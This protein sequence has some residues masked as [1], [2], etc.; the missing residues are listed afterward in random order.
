MTYRQPTTPIPWLHSRSSRRYVA[1]QTLPFRSLPQ[2]KISTLPQDRYRAALA[3]ID[4]LL[5]VLAI[6]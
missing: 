1:D 4:N 2:N 5:K 3:G 6:P